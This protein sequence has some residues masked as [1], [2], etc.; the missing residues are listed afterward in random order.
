MVG[1]DPKPDA[2][3]P[4]FH[5]LSFANNGGSKTLR[6]PHGVPVR[7]ELVHFEK[8]LQLADD[9]CFVET[10]VRCVHIGLLCMCGAASLL[11]RVACEQCDLQ[12]SFLWNAPSVDR[13]AHFGHDRPTLHRCNDKYCALNSLLRWTLCMQAGRSP[14]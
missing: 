3:E 9:G 4:M 6:P 1:S 2:T 13:S 11:A 5:R 8:Q 14:P 7:I 12:H 10:G